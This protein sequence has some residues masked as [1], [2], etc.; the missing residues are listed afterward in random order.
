MVSFMQKSRTVSGVEVVLLFYHCIIGFDAQGFHRC[1]GEQR[2]FHSPVGNL[3]GHFHCLMCFMCF[4]TS[5]ALTPVSAPKRM[6]L[7][8]RTAM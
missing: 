4:I 2:F 1:G 7:S 6:P 8:I 3:R 5:V